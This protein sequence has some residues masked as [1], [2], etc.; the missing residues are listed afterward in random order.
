MNFSK[1]KC[2]YIA[3]ACRK[4]VVA[5]L[6]GL[7]WFT[8][9]A[10]LCRMHEFNTT[11]AGSHGFQY[12]VERGRN[13]VMLTFNY[14]LKMLYRL[15]VSVAERNHEYKLDFSEIYRYMHYRHIII[16]IL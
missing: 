4:L 13:N 16:W 6:G 2:E 7:R 11:A 1:C 15:I 14:N 10:P 3:S 8:N 9:K 5:E 12:L